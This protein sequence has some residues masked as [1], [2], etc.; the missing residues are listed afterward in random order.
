MLPV[1]LSPIPQTAHYVS[2]NVPKKKKR[3]EKNAWDSFS[4][5]HVTQSL[6]NHF[7]DLMKTC[8]VWIPN[9]LQGLNS[10]NK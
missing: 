10:V 4:T 2:T 7:E 3:K 1:D 9:H 6:P 8:S 5:Q